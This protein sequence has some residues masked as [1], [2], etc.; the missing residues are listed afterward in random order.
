LA[1]LVSHILV[2][3]LSIVAYI[4]ALTDFSIIGRALDWLSII[5]YQGSIFYAQSQYFLA[6]KA[7]ETVMPQLHKWLLLEIIT[8]YGLIVSA[9]IFLV[10]SSLIKIEA[11]VF[12]IEEDRDTTDYITW[13]QGLYK[14][15][16]LCMTMLVVTAVMF[17][18]EDQITCQGESFI[19]PMRALL[20]VHALQ[21]VTITIFIFYVN[22][23]AGG[24][25]LCLFCGSII[26]LSLYI[27][28]AVAVSTLNGC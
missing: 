19:E 28:I 23:E 9:V 15:F 21:V 14:Y 8:F 10:L 7:C 3:S 27:Y 24:C 5:F 22:N 6:E 1:L 18:L 26:P 16:G 12:A 20:S 13:S 17:G 11:R 4:L 25:C 2:F